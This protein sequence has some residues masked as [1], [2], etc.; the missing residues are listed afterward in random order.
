MSTSCGGHDLDSTTVFSTST[1]T[2]TS[3]PT[4]SGR[5]QPP[6]VLKGS[7]AKTAAWANA[8]IRAAHQPQPPL[9]VAV[10]IALPHVDFNHCSSPAPYAMHRAG[11]VLMGGGGGVLPPI[12][13]LQPLEVG[14][15]RSFLPLSEFLT[16]Y[17][18]LRA[19]HKP[20]T[21]VSQT[22]QFASAYM[23]PC[24]LVNDIGV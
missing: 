14:M 21:D 13:L 19:Q 16:A 23:S 18:V 1:D 20:P 5:A 7:N 15:V 22:L 8:M 6:H 9:R 10:A 11:G 2:S 3:T 17:R 12:A 4:S 24:P